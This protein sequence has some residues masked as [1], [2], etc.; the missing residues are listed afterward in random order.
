MKQRINL[1]FRFLALLVALMAV[2]NACKDTSDLGMGLLPSDD[3]IDVKN[4]VENDNF[5][6]YTFTEDSIQTDEAPKSLLGSFYDPVFGLTTINFAT[7]FRLF[8]MPDYGTN[9]V[10]DSVKLY[11]YYTGVYGDTVTPQTFRIYELESALDV[12]QNYRQDINL[13]NYASDVPI[14]EII[15]TPVV[16]LDSASQ[17][18]FYQRIAVPLDHS[19]GEKLVNAPDSVMVSNDDFLEYFKGLMIESEPR[20]SEGG[21]ILTLEAEYSST[22]FGSRLAVFYN[23]DENAAE[24]EP[25]TLVNSFVISPFSARVNS[26]DHD[27]SVT[28]F[29]EGLNQEINP[30]SL[31][32]VQPTG[33]LK[34]KINI[35]QLSSWR[36]SANIAINKA[37]I[38]FQ[39]DTLAS[40]VD[41][42]PPPVQLLFTYIDEEGVENLP[43]DYWFSPLYYGGVLDTTNYTYRFNITQHLQQI[44][45]GTVPN[46]GFFLTTARKSSEAKR[47][48]IKGSNSE[49]GIQLNVTYSKYLQ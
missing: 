8:D 2:L 28:A 31:I 33:G 9:P 23:N 11:L 30:D 19:L 22:F 32:Y 20:N 46:N 44:L 4:I 21:S 39:V 49:T 48:V 25:D 18:T 36:D 1:N 26:I 35:D 41:K 3:L 7:Q 40:E 16:M 34:A 17:D 15:Y 37:E 43:A 12:D 42:Y 10:V 27:Y 29:Y 13:K 5:S 47:V 38:I 45:E 14:G 24:E 6:A